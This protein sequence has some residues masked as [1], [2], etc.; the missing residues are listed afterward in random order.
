MASLEE[1]VLELNK[2]LVIL[3][4]NL[5]RHFGKPATSTASTA[6]TAEAGK[7]GPGRPPKVAS[8]PTL[9]QV[10]AIAEKVR[11]ER[12]QPAAVELISKHG[13]KKLADMDP[14][15]YAEFI[16]ACEVALSEEDGDD[17]EESDDSL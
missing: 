17:G 6:S 11:E 12:G 3:N 8:G 13:A 15:R 4:A 16:A 1:S 7:R 9:D 14:K 2:N 10:K 5:E